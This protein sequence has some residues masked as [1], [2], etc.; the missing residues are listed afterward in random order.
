MW[1]EDEQTWTVSIAGGEPVTTRY[2]ITATGF[3]SQPH[4]PDIPGIDTFAGKIIHT[5]DWDDATT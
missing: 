5:A 1:D 2:L 3:L 4:R